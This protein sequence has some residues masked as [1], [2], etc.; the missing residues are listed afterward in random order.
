[1]QNILFTAFLVLTD[2]L[3]IVPLAFTPYVTRKTELFGVSVPML[4]SNH[5][6]LRSLRASYRNQML[7][8][9]LA[10]LLSTIILALISP[11]WSN[12]S[13]FVWLG[14]IAVYLVISFALYLPKH[15]AM[16]QIKQSELWQ[17]DH[18]TAVVTA[19]IEAP[20]KDT[21]SPAWLLLFP[22]VIGLG[23]ILL[24]A[25][26]P[27]IP[28][29]VPVHFD[30]S[31]QPDQYVPKGPKVYLPMLIIEVF[32]ALVFSGVFFM[33]RIAKRQ[34]DSAQPIESLHRSQRYRHLSSILMILLG[35]VT[36]VF[37]Q[38][39]QLYTFLG[40]SDI[41]MVM[42]AT[43]VFMVIVFI[44]IIV[45]M[46]YIGQGG[47]R[48]PLRSGRIESEINY[49][50]D[51]FWKLG[52]F[53]FNKDDPAVFVEKRFGIGWTNNYARPATWTIIA[54]FSIAILVLL[55]AI[56]ALVG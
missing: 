28:D 18:H 10:L 27:Q 6:R 12:I 9:G 4:E 43:L 23:A 15:R 32:I 20:S 47:S 52:L 50:D 24:V 30:L 37:M 38:L 35:L 36:I 49:D 22:L 40:D 44:V 56:F 17:D 39:L 51:R 48:L 7:L 8:F 55:V 41:S 46:F 2:A 13:L 54:V 26:W 33:I 1:M 29:Q 14:T 45:A 53:Y 21:A 31:G 19:S 25:I 34:I 3:L 16:K 42:L 11:A 5:P